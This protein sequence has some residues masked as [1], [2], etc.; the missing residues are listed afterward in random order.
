MINKKGSMGLVGGLVA[1]FGG[2]VFIYLLITLWGSGAV[3]GFSGNQGLVM[4]VIFLIILWIL[5]RGK[6]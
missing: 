4:L 3:L 1:L 6:K 5:T 2:I